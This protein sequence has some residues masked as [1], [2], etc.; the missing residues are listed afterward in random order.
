MRAG[1]GQ[2]S[3]EDCA[4]GKKKADKGQA[5][6]RAKT[7]Y[8]SFSNRY[9]STLERECGRERWVRSRLLCLVRVWSYYGVYCTLGRL[10]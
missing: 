1:V 6:K 7:S 8:F 5:N 10:S 4:V 3:R 2:G 9:H